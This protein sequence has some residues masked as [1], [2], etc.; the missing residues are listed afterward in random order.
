MFLDKFIKKPE[1]EPEVQHS[2]KDDEPTMIDEPDQ[3]EITGDYAHW[4]M[5]YGRGYTIY[6][7]TDYV[8]RELIK[9]SN[10]LKYT[11]SGSLDI[12]LILNDRLSYKGT[13]KVD[14]LSATMI[15]MIA[16]N[17]QDIINFG[18]QPNSKLT[19]RRI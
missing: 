11:K 17:K 7:D 15:H 10:I 12:E 5:L 16:S 9:K 1:H 13:S 4:Y 3:L 19:I 18:Y 14:R 8:Y 6:Q 2:L